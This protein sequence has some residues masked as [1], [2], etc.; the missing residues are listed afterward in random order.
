[1]LRAAANSLETRKY[2][3]MIDRRAAANSLETRECKPMIDR[4]KPSRSKIKCKARQLDPQSNLCRAGPSLIMMKTTKSPNPRS[5]C[6]QMS[7]LTKR[8]T[9]LPDLRMDNQGYR[10]VASLAQYNPSKIHGVPFVTSY[11]RR[12]RTITSRFGNNKT[13]I[14]FK[15]TKEHYMTKRPCLSLS[16]PLILGHL[17]T[18]AIRHISSDT[19]NW[20]LNFLE[21]ASL[22]IYWSVFSFSKCLIWI[23]KVWWPA[24]Q[25]LRAFLSRTPEEDN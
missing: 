10:R 17:L 11:R 25:L 8:V 6:T 22:I 4:T 23:M 24:G 14:V 16:L 20:R 21:Q 12:G 13:L 1:M 3:P 18:P 2:A 19:R 7:S 9:T 15:V 5:P